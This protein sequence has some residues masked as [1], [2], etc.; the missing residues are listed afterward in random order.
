M[1]QSLNLLQFG[2]ILA[3]ISKNWY[4]ETSK[5][6]VSVE[7]TTNNLCKVGNNIFPADLG[8]SINKQTFLLISALHSKTYTV[9]ETYIKP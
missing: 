9:S 7:N 6:V 1:T 3:S 8:G 2:R 4:T 5:N